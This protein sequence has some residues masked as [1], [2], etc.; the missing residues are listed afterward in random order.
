MLNKNNNESKLEKVIFFLKK[1]SYSDAI[2]LLEEIIKY[3]ETDFQSHYFLGT[4]YLHLKKLD[5]AELNLRKALKLNKISTSAMHNLGITLSIKKEY[6]KAN[7]QFLKVIELDPKN[8]ETMIELG[9]NYEL[10]KNIN[11]AKKY[12][13]TVLDLD[14]NNKIANRLLGYMLINVGFHKLGLNYLKKTTGLIRFDEKS[15]KIIK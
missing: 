3:D 7:E 12:Y 11:E 6:L 5:L 14:V 9:K 8:L 15:F 1:S 4:T 13:M 10:L 2:I